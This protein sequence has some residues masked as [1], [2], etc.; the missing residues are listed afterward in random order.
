MGAP[1]WSLAPVYLLPSQG[2]LTDLVIAIVSA[3]HDQTL[4]E[5]HPLVRAW[6]ALGSPS[7][8][9]SSPFGSSFPSS[10]SSGNQLWQHKCGQ[11]VV[12]NHIH[13][14]VFTCASSVHH[15]SLCVKWS[16]NILYSLGHVPCGVFA[17]EQGGRDDAQTPRCSCYKVLQNSLTN[18]FIYL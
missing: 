10:K 12:M 17:E 15:Y 7:G 1:E 16:K 6:P 5:Q 3:H 4:W 2:L 14:V 9:S 18:L 13:L 11:R 8:P